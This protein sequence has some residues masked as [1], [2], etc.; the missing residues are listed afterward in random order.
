MGIGVSEPVMGSSRPSK[1]SLRAEILAA[2][3]LLLVFLTTSKVAL[4]QSQ[5]TWVAKGS[6]PTAR[7]GNAVVAVNANIY[8]VGGRIAPS[9]CAPLGNL[10]AYASATDSWGELAPMPT[11]RFNAGAANLNGKVFVV[12]GQTACNNAVAT[13][14]AFDPVA[15][16]WSTK[17]AMP[18]ARWGLGVG[19]LNGILYAVGGADANNNVL[20]T[21]EAYNPNTDTWIPIPSMPTPRVGI[22]VGVAAGSLYAVGGIDGTGTPLAVNE[23]YSPANQWSTASPMI[24]PRGYF[25][26]GVLNGILYA[27]GGL[28]GSTALATLEAYN[29]STDTWAASTSMLAPRYGSSGMGVATGAIYV[30]GGVNSVNTVVAENDV[31]KPPYLPK[32]VY[33]LSSPEAIGSSNQ[34]VSSIWGYTV[35]VNTGYLT[36]MLGSPF[37]AAASGTYALYS[38]IAV[39]P[40]GRYLYY[41]TST[42]AGPNNTGEDGVVSVF[43]IDVTTGILKPVSGSPFKTGVSGA[44]SIV[45][46]PTGQYLYVAAP[47][48]TL[49]DCST[50]PPDVVAILSVDPKKGKLEPI[51]ESPISLDPN[52]RSNVIAVDPGGK[53]LYTAGEN[54][55]TPGGPAL[56]SSYAVDPT[57]GGL[58]LAGSMPTSDG[59]RPN[60]ISVD[61][62]GQVVYVSTLCIWGIVNGFFD[63]TAQAGDEGPAATGAVDAFVVTPQSGLLTPATGTP[64]D[65]GALGTASVTGDPNG[66]FV[67]TANNQNTA[68]SNSGSISL[69]SVDLR[70]GVLDAADSSPFFLAQGL[71]G[72]GPVNTNSVTTDP[73]GRFVYVSSNDFSAIPGIVGEVDNGSLSVLNI[74]VARQ[75]LFP[76]FATNDG[77]GLGWAFPTAA[78]LNTS[79]VVAVGAL[80]DPNASLVSISVQPTSASIGTLASQQFTAVAKYSDGSLRYVTASATWTSSNPIAA[81]IGNGLGQLNSNFYNQGGSVFIQGGAGV[82]TGLEGGSTLITATYGGISGSASLT[83]VAAQLQSIALTP[84]SPTIIAGQSQQFIATGTYSDG[85]TQVVSDLATWSSGTTSVATINSSGKAKGINAGTTNITASIGGVVGETTLTVTPAQLVSINLTPTSPTIPNPGSIPFTAVGTYTNS[86]VVDV[87][88]TVTW[89]SATTTVATITAAG[90]ASAVS[91]G[92]S[93]IQAALSGVTASTTLTVT[94]AQLVSLALNPANVT[95][96][97]NGVRQFGAIGTFS[98]ASTFDLTQTVTWSTGD[99]TVATITTGGSAKAVGTGSTK[100]SASLNGITGSANLTVQVLAPKCVYAVNNGDST[101]SAYTVDSI[102]GSLTPVPGSPFTAGVAQPVSIS[103]DPQDRFVYV[104]GAAVPPF[105]SVFTV[106]PASGALTPVSGSPFA[107]GGTIASAVASDPLGRFVYAV[108]QSSGGQQDGSI[109]VFSLDATTGNLTPVAGSPFDSGGR[110]PSSVTPD[111]TGQ[112][113]YVTNNGS[114][115]VSV[116]SVNATTGALTPLA[117]VDS[118]GTGPR[119]ASL[120]PGDR[121]LY[122]DNFSSSNIGAFGADPATGVLTAIFGSPFALGTSGENSVAADPAGRFVYAASSCLDPT[123]AADG[124]ISVLSMNGATG[125]LTQI[126]GSPFDA[127]GANTSSA[128]PDPS[129][130]FIYAANNCITNGNCA[131]GNVSVFS[132][133]AGSGALTQVPGISFP[134][135]A[136]PIAL[137]AFATIADPQATLTSVTVLPATA[138]IAADFTTQQFTAVGTYSDGSTRFLTVSATWSSSSGSIATVGNGAGSAGFSTGVGQ[139]TATITATFAGVSGS[140]TLTVTPPVLLGIAISP[141]NPSVALGQTQQ[142]TATGTYS[143]GS[144]QDLT[145]AVS[146]S[147]DFGTTITSG[148][149]ATDPNIGPTNIYAAFGSFQVSTTLTVTPAVIASIQVK[150]TNGTIANATNVQFVALAIYT[151]GSAQNVT[152]SVTWSSATTSV[153]TITTSGLATGVGPGSSV[154]Q[155]VFGSFTGSTT[156]TVSSAQLTS[157][158]V[159]PVSVTLAA[160]RERQ[161]IATGTF[162]DG[163]TQDLT[164]AVTWSTGNSGTATINSIGLSIGIA[165]GNTSVKAI[166]GAVTGSAVLSVTRAFAPKFSYALDAGNNAISAYTVDAGSGALTQ[167]GGSPIPST[168]SG[169]LAIGIDPLGRFVFVADQCNLNDCNSGSIV[170]FSAD[171]TTGALSPVS[172]APFA[173]G[174]GQPG[175]V[176]TDPSG[177][178]VFVVNACNLSNCNTGSVG[179]FALDATTGTLTPVPGSPFASG[180]SEPTSASV[181]PGGKFLF[182]GN[183]CGSDCNTGSLA[184]YAIDGTTGKLTPAPGSPYSTGGGLI[185]VSA[186]A[187]GRFLYALTQCIGSDCS[188]GSVSVFSLDTGTGAL[189]PIA[190][191]PFS[192]AVQAPEMM[193]AD[194]NG[195]FVYTVTSCNPSDCNNGTVEVFSADQTTGT[196]TLVAGSP[197]SSAGRFT[198]T[199]SP[200]PGGNFLYVPNQCN[201]S[202]CSSGSLSVFSVNGATG[203]LTGVAGSPFAAGSLIAAA[204]LGVT[205]DP[206]AT[207]QSISVQPKSASVQIGATQQFVATGTYSDGTSRGSTTSA[208]WSSSDSSKATVSNSPG[209]SGQTTGV[210]LGTT[211]IKAMVGTASDTASLTV[212]ATINPAPNITSAN[213]VTFTAGQVSTFTVTATGNPIPSLSE[214][215]ALPGGVN[216]V[217]NGD[218]TGTLSGTPAGSGTFAIDFV[219]TNIVSQFD[220]PFTLTVNPASAPGIY[221]P[222]NNSAFNGNTATFQWIAFPSATAY[223]LD[224]GKEQ[225]GNE[226]FQSNSLAATVLSQTVNSLP[227][228]GSPVWARWYYLLNG[229]WQ[230]VD[231]TYTAF[232]GSPTKGMIVTPVPNSTLTSGTVTFAWTA[233]TGATAY[234]IDAGNVAGGNQY[235]QSG[236]LGNVLTDTVSGL[237]TNGS[238]VYVTLYSMV[239]GQWLSNAYQYTA[240]NVVAAEGVITSPTPGLP[241]NSSNVTFTWTTGSGTA[242]WLDVGSTAGGSQY[243]QSGSLNVQ[244]ETVN[245]LPEDGSTIYVTLYSLVGGVWSGKAYTYTALSGSSCNGTITSPTPGTTFP[246]SGSGP[247]GTGG[248]TQVFTWTPSV[249][250]G[251]STAVTAYWLDA[252]QAGSENAYFQSGNL[253]TVTTGTAYF[254]PTE[255]KNGP[256]CT[257]VPPQ[258]YCQDPPTI[259]MTLWALVGGVWQAAPAVT[260]TYAPE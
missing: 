90:L 206:N 251:C 186:E 55:N 116:F 258:T 185:S 130:R 230:F 153:A 143:D 229:G 5:G 134:A 256:G 154:I 257:I 28:S 106:D 72:V 92:T 16:T 114:D 121:F 14:E 25:E 191:S 36:P 219:A 61:P 183:Q 213:N 209:S 76:I 187:S 103:L 260:Y 60:S 192:A 167:V 133:D 221:S 232:G 111:P 40:L 198:A 97:L 259:Y 27:A 7:T 233:G 63:C 190:G 95:L 175:F 66:Q 222:A 158:A 13:L 155:A 181:D 118:Q 120:D 12:G 68:D 107:T 58:S 210:A 112:F 171:G 86:T 75:M 165:A 113:L 132:V 47:C 146:W 168:P 20:S 223:W 195:R 144:T 105:V 236:N 205:W 170:V 91:P 119:S 122:V 46:D 96:L 199:V 108:N 73:S 137:A 51:D 41:L 218:G 169:P 178:F 180:G 94:G 177:R 127:G 45:A 247:G 57:S 123:C 149:L 220:Q 136:S 62:S 44:T 70:T 201:P 125:A 139:G 226:Y 64:F 99:P 234:W 42:V 104:I 18:T 248:P 237:P 214:V 249:N 4:A 142:F 30:I 19:V 182:V 79:P 37:P 188:T 245:G 148:G 163:T 138:S 15:G 228:D 6:M 78:E 80:S 77:P 215:G 212:T 224:V 50:N 173:S 164:Q 98:D 115:G 9:F 102:T 33:A 179:A 2:I 129:G 174:G 124:A 189:T 48:Q 147:A 242:W 135:G 11:A 225:G 93:V 128:I 88:S 231:Y 162:S 84:V 23:S 216:F 87:T 197:F 10:E 35:D 196:L 244:T 17:T 145:N 255:A 172:G 71:T 53:F 8:S 240:F 141:M 101:I 117:A 243:S 52:T 83:S 184:V 246:A 32:F 252:G 176:S 193:S 241:L 24:T 204:G 126:S 39:D 202:D 81:I 194:P 207:L 217:D 203:A 152:P 131:T 29:A 54:P 200:D 109:T 38:S 1:P 166:F 21:V 49:L 160:N 157:L 69:F 238:T 254:L 250:P 89:T 34:A 140:A 161:F 100:V 56:I 59:I 74:D 159:T 31:F 67:Y 43:T 156:L 26:I 235:L 3:F 82:A 110:L 208:T 239:N 85:S 65:T 151:D 253:G 227:S 211:T 22:A 150:P